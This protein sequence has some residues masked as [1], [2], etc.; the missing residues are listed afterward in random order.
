VLLT[1]CTNC[2]DLKRVLQHSA[3]AAQWEETLLAMLNE[4]AELSDADLSVLLRYLAKN[5]GPP[6]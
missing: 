2:H 6:R 3:T 5:F 4:G 1:V